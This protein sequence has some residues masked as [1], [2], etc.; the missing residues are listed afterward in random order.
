MGTE[1]G[2]VP[3]RQGVPV[4]ERFTGSSVKRME[5]PSLLTGHAFFVADA[6]LPGMLHASFVRSPLPHAR[7]LRVDA[8][9]ALEAPGVVAVLDGWELAKL[10]APHGVTGELGQ[11]K[12]GPDFSILATDKVRLVGDPVVLVV[13]EDRYLAEDACDLVE[14][15]Y[16]ELPALASAE[17]AL[18]ADAALVFDALPGNLVSA[19]ERQEFGDVSQAFAKADLTVAAQIRQ[20]RHQNVPM[21]GRGI[22]ASFDKES[23][24]LLVNAATQGV[25]TTRE[26]L[27]E[28]LSLPQE[29]VRVQAFDIGGSFGLKFG[30]SREEVAVCA[31]S[32][33][34]ARP[35]AWIE[36]RY[37]NL[38]ASGQAREESFRAEAAVT[39]EGRVLG[40]NVEM[41]IDAGAY[42]GLAAMVVPTVREMV[43]GPYRMEALA[44]QA[45][46]AAT[47]KA[48]YVAY[49]GPWASETFLRERLMDLIAKELGVE[50]LELRLRNVAHR[51]ESPSR[52]VTGP[53]LAGLTTR[54]SL[55]LMA[56]LVNLPEF[57]R[58]QQR[59][60]ERGRHLGIGFATFIEPA[61]GPRALDKP[62]DPDEMEHV[63][64]GLDED[65]RLLVYT[66]QMP[67]GQG[68]RTTLAQIA[69][70]QFGVDLS[71][72][73]VV[74]GDTDSAPPGFGTGG[75]RSATMTG[76][77][78]L[79]AARR[80]RTKVLEV[81]G[82]LVDVSPD[83]LEIRRGE[84]FQAGAPDGLLS[85]AE[86]ARAA[87]D[88]SQLPEGVDRDLQATDVFDGG[89]GG[90]SGGTHCALVE[91]DRE[92]GQV[93]VLRY[94]VVEDCGELI[95]PAVVEGQIRGGV[96]QGIG[97]VL[98][99]RS[100]YD[101]SGQF[102][103]GT[104]MDYLLPTAHDIPP[105]EIHHLQSVLLDQDVNF[106]GVGE[107]GMIAA[108]AAVCN[109][110]ADALGSLG[111]EIKEQHLPPARILELIAEAQG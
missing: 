17:Q 82:Q 66:A 102:L 2:S 104:L 110:I 71:Q 50:P 88:G 97:A 64:V 8:A 98:L 96:A 109:A 68:H 91:V 65:G 86:V 15:E 59:A 85:V 47:N 4:G 7:I 39:S 13:A 1:A 27:A 52:M 38:S 49:R 103:S 40:L 31:A 92:T 16:E 43:P 33:V 29:K 106:R 67:H 55:E 20:H 51:G 111:V 107:G 57:R 30:A 37:E 105:I 93:E 48:S 24:S 70:D 80:L 22:V 26:A 79:H 32:M 41:L 5:D 108:P 95:N 35:V 19:G 9:R 90:W 42:P 75:S 3:G 99:E 77:A 10:A 76:G 25:N 12:D 11:A 53:S 36:D 72:V 69:A 34:L 100:V 21:E 46:V 61:P 54:E 89:E 101:E 28:Q 73:T 44:F 74:V 84:V 45:T 87:R 58:R 63:R 83:Q 60:L 94:L 78:T 18:A 62:P 56:E 81:A 6:R 23:G 14:V